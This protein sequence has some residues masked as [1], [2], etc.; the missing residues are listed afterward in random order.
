VK[1]RWRTCRNPLKVP[2][3][4]LAGFACLLLASLSGGCHG[5]AQQ[6]QSSIELLEPIA[7]PQAKTSRKVEA[8][9]DIVV[10]EIA[11]SLIGEMTKPIYPPD[12]LAARAGECVIYVTITID[13]KGRVSDVT[14]S[15]DRLNLPGRFTEAFLE[16]IRVAV[17]SWNFEPTRLVY[18]ERSGT[19]ENKYLYAEVVPSRTDI[20]FT[21]A[22]TGK[23]R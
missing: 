14:P 17:A 20:K 6:G 13:A 2:L 8:S 23:V 16:A 5:V 10:D 9:K 12:A 15:W 18:W 4:R 3:P 22:A 7:S 19:D 21:F 1:R 11:P